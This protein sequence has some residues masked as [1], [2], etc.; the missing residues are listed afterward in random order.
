MGVVKSGVVESGVWLN[1]VVVVKSGVWLNVVV[2]VKSGVGECCVWCSVAQFSKV[3]NVIVC[4]SVGQ[5]SVVKCGAV[6]CR[7]V[8]FGTVHYV[9]RSIV[10]LHSFRLKLCRVKYIVKCGEV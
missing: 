3:L 6:W 7:V 9:F 2:V 8:Q 4:D 5:C 1:V 10:A